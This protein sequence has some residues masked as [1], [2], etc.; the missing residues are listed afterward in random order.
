MIC[1]DPL[2]AVAAGTAEMRSLET[3]MRPVL[4]LHAV[5]SVFKVLGRGGLELMVEDRRNGSTA[6][7]CVCVRVHACVRLCKTILIKSYV[8]T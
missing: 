1:I 8:S 6:P 4:G 3:T 5:W 2:S 7:Q